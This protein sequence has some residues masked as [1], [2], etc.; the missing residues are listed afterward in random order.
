MV[1]LLVVCLLLA[2]ATESAG[3]AT[4]APATATSPPVAATA[5][6][7]S[8]PQVTPSGLGILDLVEGT[9]PSAHSGMSAKVHYTGWLK[10]GTEFD[11]SRSRGPFQFRLG[12]GQVIPGWDEGLIGMKVGGKRK[13]VIPP[14][15]GYGDRGSPPVI[16]PE[17]ELTFEIELLGVEP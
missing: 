5:G 9:G 7:G 15:L 11:T 10:N 2:C 1:R 17:A 13:L 16:P 12:A 4:A 14:H 6:P 8:K 3:P